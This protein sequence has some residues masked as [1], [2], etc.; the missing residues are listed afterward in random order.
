MLVSSVDF[1][2]LGIEDTTL[3][4]MFNLEQLDLAKWQCLINRDQFEGVELKSLILK[5]PQEGSPKYN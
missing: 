4:L 3:L 1:E 5:H 2:L